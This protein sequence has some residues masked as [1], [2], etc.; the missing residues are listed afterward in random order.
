MLEATTSFKEKHLLLSTPST[1]VPINKAQCLCAQ[2]KVE[3]SGLFSKS[4]QTSYSSVKSYALINGL[5]DWQGTMS[6]SFIKRLTKVN[7]IKNK[8]C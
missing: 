6:L 5:V 4:S 1:R 3:V 7:T 2:G 8:Q